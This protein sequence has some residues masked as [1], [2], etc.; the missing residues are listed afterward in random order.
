MIH[1]S[2]LDNQFYFGNYQNYKFQ[3]PLENIYQY[4]NQW[5][6]YNPYTYFGLQFLA[7]PPI[8][9]TYSR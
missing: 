2:S 9:Q 7:N 4:G 3:V 6:Y 1:G 8:N 5:G